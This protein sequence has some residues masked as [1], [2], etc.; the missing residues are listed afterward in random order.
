MSS[1]LH[2]L[3][4]KVKQTAMSMGADEVSVSVSEGSH[5]TIQRRG[6]KVEQ[7]AEATTRGL[8]ISLMADDRWSSHSTSDLRPEALEPFL[9][10][11]L[12]ATSYLE[13]DPDRK[14]VEGERCGRGATAEE[15]DQLDPAWAERSATDRGEHALALEAAVDAVSDERAISS[16]T[17]VADG[18]SRSVRVMSNGFSGEHE[19]AWFSAGGET[20][21]SDG[22][23]RPEAYAYFG[24]RYLADLP[25]PQDIA[26]E[27]HKRATE[28]LGSGPIESGTYPLVLANRAAGRILGVLGGPLSA[29]SIF[30]KRSCLADKLGERIG[31]DKFTLIDDPTVPRGLSSRPWDGD[32]LRATPRTIVDKGVLQMHYVNVYYG[33]KLDRP[34]TTGGR[35][36]WIV[37]AGDVPIDDILARYPKAIWVDGFLGGNSNSATGDFSF[38]IR[39]QLLEHGQPVKSL[40]EMNISGNALTIMDKLAEVGDDVWKYSSV[41]SPT[42]VFE[43]VQFSGV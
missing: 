37:P 35:S 11:A 3:A 43:D 39:G 12:S 28:R 16:A 8:V 33:R 36:N 41:M 14:Q 6:G 5:T 22:D 1:E 10:R 7:A 27:L 29:G 21:L 23:K 17:Y 20:T 24:A 31:S 32:G 40:S 13:P 15:L 30:E 18:W 25:S 9:Q 26:A 42:L 2:D 4:Q 34:P 19:G 38:G